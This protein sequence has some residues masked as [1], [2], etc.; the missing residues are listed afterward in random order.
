MVA[1]NSHGFVIWLT[2]LPGSGKTTTASLLQHALSNKGYK[3]EILDGDE[4]RKKMSPELGFSKVDRELHAKRVAYVS[5]LLSKNGIITIVALI[6][7]FRSIRQ[8][9]RDLIGDFVEVWVKCSLETCRIRDPKGL[10][11]KAAAGGITN[12]TGLQDPY[13]PPLKPEVM[14]DTEI[15]TKEECVERILQSLNQLRYVS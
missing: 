6:S 12:L 10:Y 15:L 8:Y 4:V 11:K 9:A 13:E 1:A 3:V 7:P 5:H 2:G 14:I